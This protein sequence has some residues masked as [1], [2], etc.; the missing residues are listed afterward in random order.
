[1]ASFVVDLWES[2]FT[3]GPTSTLIKATNL[4]FAALQFVLLLLLLATYSIH[5]VILSILCAGLWWS[6]NWFA[7]EL[8]AHQRAEEAKK[9]AQQP[10][11]TEDSETEVETTTIAEKQPAPESENVAEASV[12][13]VETQG[14]VKHRGPATAP[15]APGT[16]SSVSTE[17][18]WEKVSE[19]END[20]DK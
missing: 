20:K 10:E 3:P 12:E 2:I 4:S 5:C 13:A 19:N 17:D 15:L 14:E 18:E 7:A 6:I 16:Q 1:M 11:A 8:A 9:L